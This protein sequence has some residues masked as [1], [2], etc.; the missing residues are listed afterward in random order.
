LNLLI[1]FFLTGAWHGI[2]PNFLV[3][4][5]YFG[6]LLAIESVGLGRWLKRLP[7]FFQHFYALLMVLLG[8]VFFRLQK[9]ERW[10]TFFGSLAGMNGLSNNITARTLNIL[11]YIPI[12]IIAII[13]CIPVPKTI[14][15][16]NV[17]VVNSLSVVIQI[18]L[19][20]LS[21]AFLVEGG[22]QSFLYRQF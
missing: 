17:K 22:Y 13:L 3:W 11:G 7:R 6:F 1:V 21:I 14:D 19:L 16:S 8:W 18:A 9:P 20:I 12:V 5:G 10:G 2:S 15:F 4:G